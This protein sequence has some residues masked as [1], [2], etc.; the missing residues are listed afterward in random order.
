MPEAAK[1]TAII[2]SVCPRCGTINKS[3][4]NRCC[5]RGG[6]WFGNCG[7][8]GN[9][10]LGH[11]W[12]EGIQACKTWPQSKRAIGQQ[13]NGAR[14]KGNERSNDAG[15]VN[16]K[17]FGSTSARMSTPMP[18]NTT[19]NTR[20]NAS[21]T[22]TLMTVSPD[23]TSTETSPADYHGFKPIAGTAAAMITMRS[24][25]DNMPTTTSASTATVTQGCEKLVNI[26]V[27]ISLLNIIV[28]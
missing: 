5:G 10:K 23:H 22:P 21:R 28:V 18:A 17:T 1:T 3:G 2:R 14:Q 13:L 11:S 26:A 8:A 25:S 4:K 15:M 6:S 24:S 7:R 16:P 9:A 12:H 20:A 27:L 19:V